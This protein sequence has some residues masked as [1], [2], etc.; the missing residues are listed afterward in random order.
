[1][2]V[3]LELP[4]QYFVT[5]TP[6]EVVDEIKLNHALMQYRR[7]KLSI[8]SACELTQRNIYEFMKLCKQNQIEI[9]HYEE[10]ELE[11]EVRLASQELS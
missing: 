11:E 5:A 9:I 7:G 8:G 2:Q 10:G 6:Q 3:T 1:M 4:D